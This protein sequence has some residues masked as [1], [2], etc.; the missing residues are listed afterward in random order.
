MSPPRTPGAQ[1]STLTGL[2]G[3]SLE[4][5]RRLL[6]DSSEGG[7]FK[8][9]PCHGG[10]GS[11]LFGTPSRTKLKI[12]FFLCFSVF[13]D[14][15]SFFCESPLAADCKKASGR[16]PGPLFGAPGAS[17]EPPRS[18]ILYRVC[19]NPDF[20][21]KNVFFLFFFL[22]LGVIFVFFFLGIV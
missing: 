18:Q 5:P 7:R 21:W 20:S 2:L 6:G 11:L 1:Q 17:P 14:V 8:Q 12:V 3:D 15:F 10:L 13:F 4:T 16:L 9:A 22:V 19:S